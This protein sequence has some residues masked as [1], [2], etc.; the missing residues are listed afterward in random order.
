MEKSQLEGQITPLHGNM[1]YEFSEVHSSP[2][3]C[4]QTP[5]YS[6]HWQEITD[7]RA[8]YKANLKKKHKSK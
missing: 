3:I 1:V 4:P 7:V 6:S 5:I 8:S 2:L